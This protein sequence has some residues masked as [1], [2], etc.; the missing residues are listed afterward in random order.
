MTVNEFDWDL[1]DEQ[2]KMRRSFAKD[3]VKFS[4]LIDY[5]PFSIDNDLRD[6][7]MV[8]LQKAGNSDPLEG[9]AHASV[10]EEYGEHAE[11]ADMYKKRY[12]TD[13]F[14]A[15]KAAAKLEK[16]EISDPKIARL[17]MDFNYGD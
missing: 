13:T 5:P 17:S 4:L 8:D 15:Q 2:V 16:M 3:H 11:E 10:K 14:E 7:F 6:K 12:G 9:D 1:N